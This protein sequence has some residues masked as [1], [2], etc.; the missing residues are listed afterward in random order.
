MILYTN[1]VLL[2]NYKIKVGQNSQNMFSLKKLLEGEIKNGC[3]T[4]CI[5]L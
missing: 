2:V 1:E 5:V 3:V 4:F